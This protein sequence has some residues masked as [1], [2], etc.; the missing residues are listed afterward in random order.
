VVVMTRA[1]V[2]I[3]ILSEV[4]GR[5]KTEVAELLNSIREAQPGDKFDEDLPDKD[6]ALLMAELRKEKDGILIWLLDGAA[7]VRKQTGEA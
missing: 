2:F 4:S 1:E 3:Q 7:R 6:A 5:P